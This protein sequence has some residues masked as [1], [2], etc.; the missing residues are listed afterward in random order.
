ML[1]SLL[2]SSFTPRP[3]VLKLI[4]TAQQHN[5]RHRETTHMS[6]RDIRFDWQQH[7]AANHMLQLMTIA[8]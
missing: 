1:A 7:A 4:T 8:F 6:S 3:K 2:A 5:R